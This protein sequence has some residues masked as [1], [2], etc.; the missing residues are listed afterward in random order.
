MEKPNKTEFFCANIIFLS[1]PKHRG[2]GLFTGKSELSETGKMP[3]CW[4]IV[5]Y[6]LFKNIAKSRKIITKL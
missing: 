2:A 6:C 3:V 5:Y 1:F 4:G